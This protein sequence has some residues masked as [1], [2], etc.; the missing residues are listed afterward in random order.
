MSTQ[1]PVTQRDPHLSPTAPVPDSQTRSPGRGP[2]FQP[3]ERFNIADYFLDDRIREGRGGRIALRTD[4]GNLTYAEVQA[5]A[6]RFGN[7]LLDAGVE[8]EQRVIIALPDGPEYVAALFGVLKIGAVVVMVNPY[9]R[10][11]AIEYFFRYTRAVAAFVHRENRETFETAARAA[12][13]ATGLRRRGLKRLFVVGDEG[14]ERELAAAPTSLENYPTHRD[15]PAIWLFS[16]GTSGRPKAAVQTHTSYANSTECYGKGVI[17]YTE[18]DITL[19]VPKLFFGYAMGSNLFFPFS[20]GASSVLF[21]ERSTPEA[22]FE[23][24]ARHR[25]TILI[26]VP[27]MVQQM[28]SH[29]D[30]ARQDFSSLRL[31]TSAGEALPVELYHR[32]KA[33]FGVELLDGLGTAEM[34]HIFLSN[35]LGQVRPGTLGTAVPGFEVRVRDEHGN[36]LPPGEVGYLW[37]RGNSR[38]IGYWQHMERTRRAFRG[39]W[40]VSEDMLRMDEDG[41]FTYCGRADDMLKVSGKWLSPQEVENCLLQHP[42]VKEVA[43]V[44]AVDANGLVQPHAYVVRADG[45][46]A[47]DAEDDAALAEALRAFVRERL[48]SYKTPRAVFFLD[49]LPRTHLGKV[50]RGRLRAGAVAGV[51]AQ[52][53]P[54]T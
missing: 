34:W 8:P 28:V 44:G 14:F 41:Y 25:P 38:A 18:D 26:N 17:R 49:A 52:A 20:V 5:L 42:A 1:P 11:D 10:V 35:Q 31:A 23:K 6:N 36:D 30:A 53:G 4:A 33:T 32:W 47:P 3:P 40:Y 39:E 48:E 15:D 7:L 43:V 46:A 51:A 54:G 45:Y 29:P 37:V 27:T 12:A 9:L 22:I 50:D 2:E 19:S 13:D 16:G 21:P 24:I